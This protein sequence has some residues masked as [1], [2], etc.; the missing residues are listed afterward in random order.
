M[1]LFLG[2][3]GDDTSSLLDLGL[4][5]TRDVASLDDDGVGRKTTLGEDLAVAVGEAVDDGDNGRRGRETLAL[6]SGDERLG[7]NGNRYGQD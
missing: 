4:G 5:A 7:G 2:D 3:N 6:L 1:W